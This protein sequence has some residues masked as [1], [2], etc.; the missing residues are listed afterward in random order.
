MFYNYDY[1]ATYLKHLLPDTMNDDFDIE[2]RFLDLADGKHIK[3]SIQAFKTNLA[4]IYDY[5]SENTAYYDKSL[6][7]DKIKNSH[8]N[9][10]DTYPILNQLKSILFTIGFFGAYDQNQ[11]LVT[12]DHIDILRQFINNQGY[13]IKKK[14]TMPKLK[15]T[16]KILEGC[17][18]SFENIDLN[19]K[20][21]V[22]DIGKDIRISYPNDPYFLLGLK[23]LSTLEREKSRKGHH[24]IFLRCDYNSLSKQERDIN[25]TLASMISRLPE[26]HQHEVMHMHQ[27]LLDIGLSCVFDVFYMHLR[28]IYRWGK[29]EII[30]ISLSIESGYRVLIKPKKIDKYRDEMNHFPISLQEKIDKG[31]GCNKKLYNQPCQM[32]CHGYSFTIDDYFFTISDY[33]KAWVVLECNASKKRKASS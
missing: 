33:I 28:F 8:I 12:I 9:L 30:T 6:N 32:G 23:V 15:E 25:K 11:R 2:S 7:L 24:N 26:K 31:Y 18:F 20:R 14:M 4:Q 13:V 27:Q 3:K 17:G 16:L 22:C 5:I 10:A 19:D 1:M 21:L 29:R